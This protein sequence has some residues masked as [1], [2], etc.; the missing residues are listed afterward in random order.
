MSDQQQSGTYRVLC[1]GSAVTTGRCLSCGSE[2]SAIIQRGVECE[3]CGTRLLQDGAWRHDGDWYCPSCK[4]VATDGGTQQSDTERQKIDWLVPANLRSLD[5][6]GSVVRGRLVSNLLTDGCG[7][8]ISR[9]EDGWENVS[10]PTLT[11]LIIRNEASDRAPIQPDSVDTEN[12][13]VHTDT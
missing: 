4:P 5:T 1:C 2:R 12:R 7:G 9:I 11:H 13:Y 3:G 8:Q 10:T 6:V